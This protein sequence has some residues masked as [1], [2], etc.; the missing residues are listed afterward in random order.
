M[1]NIIPNKPIIFMKSCAHVFQLKKTKLFTIIYFKGKKNM[2]LF[3]IIR[4]GFI[5]KKRYELSLDHLWSLNKLI[6][7]VGMKHHTLVGN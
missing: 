6:G 7:T 3:E 1:L 5:D 4:H 2:F